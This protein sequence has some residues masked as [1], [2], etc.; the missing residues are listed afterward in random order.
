MPRLGPRATYRYSEDFMAT[1]VR[2]G[3]L[4]GLAVQEVAHSLAIH[5]YMMTPL[6]ITHT[7]QCLCGAVRFEIRGD[8]E[9]FFL[10][11][12]SHCR[13][14]SGSAHSAN[15]FSKSATLRWLSGE[16]QVTAFQLAGTR[17]ARS[18]CATCGSALPSLQMNG[19]LLVVPAGSLDGDVPLRPQGHLFTESRADWDEALEEL[20]Q[21][22]T[23]PG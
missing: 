8:F 23:V 11:H 13:K 20:P 5:P 3:E 22:P 9:A 2:L 16:A 18:F 10:C 12:C 1:A 7:G 6:P 17:H 19:T 15:L 21:F 14:G 4:E